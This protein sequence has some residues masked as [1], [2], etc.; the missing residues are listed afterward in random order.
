MAALGVALLLIPAG[1][2]LAGYQDGA[3]AGVTDQGEAVSFRVGDDRLKRLN[4]VVYAEC[5]EGPRQKVTLEGGRTPMDG[6][7]FS[8]D[9]AG[10]DGLEVSITGRI[11]DRSASGQLEVS[12]KPAGT[13]CAAETGW[14]TKLVP[15][16]GAGLKP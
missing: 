14:E 15:P 4:V 13:S 1:L 2:A 6:G 7:R 8:L 16:D 11:R 3:Y 5:E 12:L 10:A 9:R